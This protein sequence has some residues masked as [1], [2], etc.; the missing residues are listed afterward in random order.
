MSQEPVP[1]EEFTATVARMEGR[2]CALEGELGVLWQAYQRLVP[3][4]EA[5][6]AASQRDIALAK[7]SALMVIQEVLRLRAAPVE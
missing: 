5:E 3:R 7:S 4:F 6:L 2:L 1:L